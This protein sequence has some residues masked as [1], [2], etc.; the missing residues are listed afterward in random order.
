L[1]VVPFSVGVLGG[2]PDTYQKAGLERGTATSTSTTTGTTST[3]LPPL[4]IDITVLSD[5]E[6]VLVGRGSL[7][8][9]VSL[10]T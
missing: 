4:L 5:G 1:V 2:T 6:G 7:E 8:L 3:A 9:V 10:V